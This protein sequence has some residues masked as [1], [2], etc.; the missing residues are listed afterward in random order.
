VKVSN[1]RESDQDGNDEPAEVQADL[2]ASN[3]AKSDL[4]S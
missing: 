4:G 2:N 1:Q 3:S